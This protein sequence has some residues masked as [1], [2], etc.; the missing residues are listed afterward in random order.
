MAELPDTWHL[1]LFK[2]TIHPM[3][4]DLITGEQSDFYQVLGLAKTAPPEE[5][6]AWF[7]KLVT[8]FHAAGKPK[9]IDDVEWLRRIVHAYHALSD[10]PSGG[11]SSGYD[12]AAIENTSRAVDNDIARQKL[13]ALR[14]VVG[15]PLA[16]IVWAHLKLRNI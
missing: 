4:E 8:D 13:A 14:A 12:Y 15:D 2:D 1:K 16:E 5:I 11:Q 10:N 9:N 6:K 7:Q 3:G